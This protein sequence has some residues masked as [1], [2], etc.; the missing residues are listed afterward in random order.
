MF[1]I[2]YKVK[3]KIMITRIISNIALV[4]IY[5]P[6]EYNL[7]AKLTLLFTYVQRVRLDGAQKTV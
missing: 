1:R 6:K 3:A 5:F 7:N 4:V 2:E